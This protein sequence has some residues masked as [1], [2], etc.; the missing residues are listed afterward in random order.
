MPAP[1]M[2][3]L[4]SGTELAPSRAQRAPGRAGI[5]LAF[6][7]LGSGSQQLQQ[8]AR[9]D[10]PQV[11]QDWLNEV[12]AWWRRHAYYPPEAGQNGEQGNVTVKVIVRH[13]GTVELV[14]LEDQARS[15]WL[16]M[17]SVAVFRGAT[18]PPLPAGVS[19]AEIPL[20]FTIHYI[21]VN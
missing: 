13:D 8:M 15:P 4:G 16:N 7:P 3:S 17:A 21:I 11:G 5:D 18:L 1:M 9:S 20:H 2:Y 6:A 19:A 12:S 10:D 14:R